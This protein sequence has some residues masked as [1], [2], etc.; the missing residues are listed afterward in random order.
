[1]F[2]CANS[3]YTNK[4]FVLKN[5]AIHNSLNIK[6]RDRVGLILETKSF[7]VEVLCCKL[8]FNTLTYFVINPWLK[9]KAEINL[10][11]LVEE[12]INHWLLQ[13]KMVVRLTTLLLPH[14]CRYYYCFEWMINVAQL[15]CIENFSPSEITLDQKRR[16]NSSNNFLWKVFKKSFNQIKCDHH[17]CQYT[18]YWTSQI[19]QLMPNLTCW[20][21]LRTD[22]AGL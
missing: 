7:G 11:I 5:V 12:G 8:A 15:H 10:K 19:I 18:S 13:W 1:M 21:C 17:L 2:S 3:Q 20:C 14:Q 6:D 22:W 9:N 4:F 16:E